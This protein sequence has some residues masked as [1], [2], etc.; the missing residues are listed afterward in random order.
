MPCTFIADVALRKFE[1]CECLYE[2]MIMMR[3]SFETVTD[4]ISVQSIG[5]ML[6]AVSSDVVQCKIEFFE[7]LWER[8]TK[9]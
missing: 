8:M 3:R 4:L 5:Y 2:M 7:C 1:Y 6:C 9:E